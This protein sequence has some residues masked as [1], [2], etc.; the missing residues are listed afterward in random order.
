MPKQEKCV[1]TWLPVGPLWAMWVMTFVR[2]MKAFRSVQN[3]VGVSPADSDQIE[4][5]GATQFGVGVE[6]AQVG[7]YERGRFAGAPRYQYTPTL[8]SIC[9][10]EPKVLTAW[11]GRLDPITIKSPSG[12]TWSTIEEE[13]MGSAADRRKWKGDLLPVLKVAKSGAVYPITTDDLRAGSAGIVTLLE[14]T[15]K[16]G[17][18]FK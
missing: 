18:T 8:L 7:V 5:L 6:K 12:C 14:Q 15:Q 13:Y 17:A 4:A 9:E 3:W 16:H 10:I 2:G 11:I 1:R